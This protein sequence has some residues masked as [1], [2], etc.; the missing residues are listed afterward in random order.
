MRDQ[1]ET[2]RRSRQVGEMTPVYEGFLF[3]VY[4]YQDILGVYAPAQPPTNRSIDSGA[5][6]LFGSTCSKI[7][8]SLL[9]AKNCANSTWNEEIGFK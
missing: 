9:S 2:T 7:V 8:S 1:Q 6:H 4:W 3:V 5:R